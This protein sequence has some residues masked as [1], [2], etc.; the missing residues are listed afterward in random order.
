MGSGCIE[1]RAQSLWGSGVGF[2]AYEAC[3]HAWGLDPGFMD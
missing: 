1:L 2:G 3:M